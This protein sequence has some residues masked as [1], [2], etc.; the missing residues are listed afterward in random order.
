MDRANSSPRRTRHAPP[1]LRIGGQ[2]VTGGRRRQAIPLRRSNLPPLPGRAGPEYADLCPARGVG[3]YGQQL[4]PHARRLDAGILPPSAR[5]SR[6]GPKMER[7]VGGG[8]RV[9]SDP[10]A[11]SS[12]RRPGRKFQDHT[13]QALLPPPP[14]VRPGPAAGVVS[15][16]RSARGRSAAGNGALDSGSSIPNFSVNPGRVE[17]FP[18]NPDVAVRL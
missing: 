10:P 11:G 9:T 12:H 15:G 17:P 13:R 3:R 14:A 7:A 8:S 1:R 6:P 2:A 16:R 4:R 18:G 5:R